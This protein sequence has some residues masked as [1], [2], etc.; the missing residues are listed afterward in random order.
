M[1]TLGAQ[2]STAELDRL[3]RNRRKHVYAVI[4]LSFDD[5]NDLSFSDDVVELDQ[6]SLDSSCRRG[7]DRNFHLHGFDESNLV[8]VA[9]IAT[10]CDRKRAHATGDFGNDLD[11]WHC[12]SPGG[13]VWRTVVLVNGF[14][15][16]P[17]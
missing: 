4:W 3:S 16:W 14:L 8:A 9:D 11:V 10:G 6:D 7:R 1:A 5:C 12:R 17:Q 15:L 2:T 13:T